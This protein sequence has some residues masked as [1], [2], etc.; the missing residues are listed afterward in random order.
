[1]HFHLR[2]P[3]PPVVLCF[4]HAL[5]HHSLYQ[6]STKSGNAISALSKHLL[7]IFPPVFQGPQISL[8]GSRSR[9]TEL[10]Q[11][12]ERSPI[13]GASE[14]YSGFRYMYFAS[15]RDKGDVEAIGGRSRGQ[16]HFHPVKFRKWLGEMCKSIFQVRLSSQPL[17]PG[18]QGHCA[19]W[20]I[21]GRCYKRTA[22]L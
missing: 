16:K 3:L 8:C 4:T 7:Q 12:T 18:R 20:E 22:A 10:H 14:F 13:I 5:M 2:S 11:R 21:E 15:F 17:M 19:S 6:I 9:V 1:M